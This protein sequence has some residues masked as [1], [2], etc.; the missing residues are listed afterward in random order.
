MCLI[1]FYSSKALW[2]REPQ[3]H[4]CHFLSK[5]MSYHSKVSI[6]YL[7]YSPQ[8]TLNWVV[9]SGAPL[10]LLSLP[11]ASLMPGK[12]AYSAIEAKLMHICT[13]FLPPRWP[14]WCLYD[15]WYIQTSVLGITRFKSN[16]KG[17]IV[18]V[19]HSS[20]W[21]C[22]HVGCGCFGCSYSNRSSVQTAN[23]WGDDGVLQE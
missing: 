14:D 1:V 19:N 16:R 15:E 7:T 17:K 12:S 5:I 9:T 4:L 22:Q 3:N 11:Y 21:R 6:N 13:I 20:T 8:Y 2:R 10:I 18:S 23:G